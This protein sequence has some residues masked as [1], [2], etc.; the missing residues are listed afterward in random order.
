MMSKRVQDAMTVDPVTIGRSDSVVSAARLM[1]SANVGS[2]PVVDQGTPVGIVTDRDIA[3]RVVAQGKDPRE[4]KV[5]DIAT[6]QP[7][8]VHPDQRSEEHTSE[9][10]S[11]SNLVCRL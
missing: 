1:E 9:L 3:I 4:T 10:Q 8:Y 7:Y 6:D 2:V 11:Q 5:A